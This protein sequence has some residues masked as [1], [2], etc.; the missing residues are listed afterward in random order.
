LNWR[1]FLQFQACF[2]ALTLSAGTLWEAVVCGLLWL[3]LPLLW[4]GHKPVRSSITLCLLT[5]ALGPW[6]DVLLGQLELV[7][8]ASILDSPAPLWIITL[9]ACFGQGLAGPFRWLLVTKR[10]WSWPMVAIGAPLAYLAGVRLGAAELG[11]TPA[12]SLACISALWL[13]MFAV[14]KFAARHLAPHLRQ[15]LNP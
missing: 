4:L 11:H 7:H 15:P 12:L 5:I 10:W 6:A 8:Y 2:L 9:W 3:G 14:L 1:P 13:V